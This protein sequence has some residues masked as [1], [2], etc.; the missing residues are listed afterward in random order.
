MGEYKTAILPFIH[1]TPEACSALAA[2]LRDAI[3]VL[4]SWNL[5]VGFSRLRAAEQ[6]LRQVAKQGSFGE[7]DA[8]LIQTAKAAAIASDFYLISTA[9]NKDRD[10]PIAEELEVA[11]KGNLEGSNKNASPYE[12]QAQ[13]WVGMLL[14]QS[15][16][17]P[18]VPP[19]NGRRPD[20]V[21][22]LGTLD[23]GVEVKR[24]R[25]TQGIIRCLGDAAN[26]LKDY[27]LPGVIALDLSACIVSDD[28]IIPSGM[29]SA[30][31]RI[32]QL[33]YPIADRLIDYV[34]S[35]TRSDK[36]SR[37][38]ALMIL[39]R[40]WVWKSSDPPEPDLGVLFSIPAF[41]K[42]CSGLIE[43]ETKRLQVM[44]LRGVQKVSGNPVE[45]KYK[46]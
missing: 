12:I 3:A 35:Y 30:R 45:Y 37:I 5:R 43:D 23:C 32:R 46:K 21:I 15:K 36:F 41:P 44:L 13:Y 11:I 33:L 4:E 20:F 29:V 19:V 28:L 17:R 2:A 24:P 9:L 40:F 26:Q 10:D 7:S 14:A 34:D 1:L 8:Q 27:G 42:A 25:S 6:H 38:I 22:S 18:K 16:L 31:E 39:A